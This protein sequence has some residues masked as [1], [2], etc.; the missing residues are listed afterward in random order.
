MIPGLPP[1]PAP[2]T[3]GGPGYIPP[4]LPGSPE[5]IPPGLPGSPGFIAPGI[6]GSPWYQLRRRS[7]NR[8]EA[9]DA[10]RGKLFRV[11]IVVFAIVFVAVLG[12]IIFVA[13]N[14]FGVVAT[15]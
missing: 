8:M 3:P 9:G 10:G 12:W 4:G 14:V 13:I 2:G 11:G 15:G 6:P 7:V 5:F 1:E